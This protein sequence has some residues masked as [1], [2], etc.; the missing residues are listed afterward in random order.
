LTT[1][2]S[3]ITDQD[4]SLVLDSSAVINLLATGNPHPILRALAV[5]LVV[6]QNVMDEIEEGA[7]SGRAEFELL[8]TVISDQ[9]VRIQRLDGTALEHFF[10]LVSGRTADTLGDGE[11]ATLA[12][13]HCNGFSAVIDEKKATRI[14]AERFWALRLATTVDILAHESVRA[15][16]GEALLAE[17]TFQALRLARMQVREHQFDWVAQLIGPEKVNV[18]PSLRRHV[19]RRSAAVG[20]QYTAIES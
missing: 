3:C 10:A 15:S 9:I 20:D 18:C 2:L 16:L 12:L 8:K 14:A 5:P 17:S 11:A 4:S 19:R 6:T 13:A 7:A 1:F